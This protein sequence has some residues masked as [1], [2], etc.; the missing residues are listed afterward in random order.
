MKYNFLPILQ[1]P[2]SFTS[3]ILLKFLPTYLGSQI[4]ELI[5]SSFEHTDALLKFHRSQRDF[6]SLEDSEVTFNNLNATNSL[7]AAYCTHTVQQRNKTGVF[8]Y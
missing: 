4:S 2:Q 6:S 5:C 1:P 8:G 7:V 3:V